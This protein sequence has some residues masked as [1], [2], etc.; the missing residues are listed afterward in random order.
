MVPQIIYT[1][2]RVFSI[3]KIGDEIVLNYNQEKVE[4]IPLYE[5]RAHRTTLK[6]LLS[7]YKNA[8]YIII[9]PGFFAP[10]AFSKRSIDFS[11][12]DCDIDYILSLPPESPAL[13]S[14]WY[15]EYVAFDENLRYLT[16]E[17]RK[18]C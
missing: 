10:Y 3:Q 12:P 2:K 16:Y 4:G 15:I 8:K 17:D 1:K 9:L 5:V 13:Y 7:E 18:E 11:S 6:E 14:Y